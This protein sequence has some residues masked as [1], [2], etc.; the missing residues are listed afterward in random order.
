MRSSWTD[1]HALYVAMK[2][3]Q[4]QKHQTHNDLDVGDFVLDAL[5]TRWAGELG[6]GD[7]TSMN[8]FSNDTQGS[9]RWLYYRK[10]T[11][12]QNTI[13]INEANQNV[14][15][16]PTVIFNSSQTTQGSSTVLTVPSNST[17]FWTTDMTSAYFGATSVQRGVRLLNARKQ[18]LLQDE[19]NASGSI[20]WRMHTNAT[21]T[22]S[23]NGTSATLNLDGQVMTVSILNAPSGAVFTTSPAVRFFVLPL[24]TAGGSTQPWCDSIDYFCSCGIIYPG[25]SV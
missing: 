6:S 9:D 15:A 5:G 1:Q 12:G 14:L 10:A 25:S 21:V 7:Y 13:N 17:A 3:G 22:I 18:V 20:M 4:L 2:A 11:Q 16:A 23:S 19:I 24:T 8:Y